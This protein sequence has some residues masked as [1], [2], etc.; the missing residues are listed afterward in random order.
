ML[1]S[2]FLA[3]LM[4]CGCLAENS[5]A[6][7]VV[8]YA[9]GD[10]PYSAAEDL[11]LPKQIDELPDDGLFV[12]H[13]GD[14]KPGKL[15]CDEAVYE[16]V[17][18]M[19]RKSRTPLFIIPG[20]NEWNDCFDPRT[21]WTYWEKYFR[22]FDEQWKHELPVNRQ[23]ERD[24]NF[25]LMY[26]GVL[27]LGLNLVGGRVHDRDEW[28]QRHAQ[29]LAWTKANLEQHGSDARAIVIF[30]HALPRPDHDDYFEGLNT[31]A[32]ELDKPFLYLHGDG[33]RWVHD[34]PF[35]A[36]K[37]LRVEVD[38]GGIAPPVKVTVT[39]DPAE[40]FLFDRRMPKTE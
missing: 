22:R 31:L 11:L 9:M 5:F 18:G 4:L 2:S 6:D 27:F 28:K 16:K 34:R 29:C 7:D 39:D 37:I 20:D 26:D 36:K 25:A 30:G 35:K 10:V 40:P 32:A 3:S 17:S 23:P 13:V 24:E 19:L 21:S 8:F 14:I 1:R 33:H 38:Q 15:P 12:V